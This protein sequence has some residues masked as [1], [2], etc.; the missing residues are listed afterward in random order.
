ML[1][2]KGASRLLLL[3]PEYIIICIKP[4]DEE[5]K[6]KLWSCFTYTSNKAVSLDKLFIQH[7]VQ[8]YR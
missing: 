8:I 7:V 1:H 2:E 5:K 3:K 6:C 4:Q